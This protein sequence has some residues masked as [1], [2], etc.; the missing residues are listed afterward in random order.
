[1]RTCLSLHSK[2]PLQGMKR[3]LYFLLVITNAVHAQQTDSLMIRRLYDG[4]LQ[5]E[6]MDTHLR[7]LTKQIGARISGSPQARQAVDWA[8]ATMSA[9]Q[10]DSIYLQPVTVPH[11]VRGAKETATIEDVQLDICA[12]G[13]SIAANLTAPVV[14]IRSWAELEKADVKGK[15]VFYN[16]PMDAREVET[17]KA[18]LGAVD[19]RAQGAIA[20]ARKGA[21]A[22]LTRSLTLARDDYPHTGAMSYDPAVKK[23]PAAALSTNSAD[24]LSAILKA[25]PAATLFLRMYCEQLP[26][27]VSYNV[28]AELKGTR[29][30]HEFVTVGAHL[31]SWDLG[32]GASDDGTGVVQVMEILRLFKQTGLQP[33]RTLRFILYMNEEAGAH[34][35]VQY[36]KEAA[37]R[38]ETHIA[39]IESDAGGFAPRGFRIDAPDA[40]LQAWAQLLAPYKAGGLQL[41]QRG[42]DLVPMKGQAKALLSLDCDDSRLFYIHHSVLDTYDK[43]NPREVAMGAGTMA[44]MAALLCKYGL[45][46]KP[47][48]DHTTAKGLVFVSGQIGKGN[49]FEEEAD[50]ALQQAATI[51]SKAGTSMANAV[52]VTV[53]LK[54]M[55]L[56]DTFNKVYK[57]HF[58]APYPARTCVGVHELVKGANV[59]ISI[60]ARAN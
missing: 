13:G 23:I 9:L 39:A 20:A 22:A 46:D 52:N 3:L 41:Q 1:M 44:A 60:I 29:Y 17:F 28:I 35:G 11:W 25:R 45:A 56:F 43:V 32:E 7:Y 36:A 34:G 27:E 6:G 47:F 8:Y 33:A 15:I 26:D 5:S 30:P 58:S 48:S 53:Y 19:Q 37:A 59:E 55:T 16:R 50:Q 2:I 54:D 40:Q 10:P 51:L 38:N 42:V 4:A 57:K 12:L 18:Y 21:V 14:E 24:R 31:D 49:T